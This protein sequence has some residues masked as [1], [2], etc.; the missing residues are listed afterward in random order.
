MRNKE[1]KQEDILEAVLIVIAIWVIITV[2]QATI[3]SNKEMGQF[4]IVNLFYRSLLQDMKQN[5]R[6]ILSDRPWKTLLSIIQT[7]LLFT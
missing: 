5:K 4:I 3:T 7:N 1:L 2:L 6:P